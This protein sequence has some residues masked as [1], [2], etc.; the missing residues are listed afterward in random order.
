MICKKCGAELDEDALF[1]TEC[2]E[3]VVKNACPECGSELSEDAAFCTECGKKVAP[4][5]CPNCGKELEDE[6]KFCVYCGASI[7]QQGTAQPKAAENLQQGSTISANKASDSAN[8]KQAQ[9]KNKAPLIIAIIVAVIAVLAIAFA[10]RAYQ[11]KKIQ[12]AIQSFTEDYNQDYSRDYS[13][14]YSSESYYENSPVEIL[15]ATTAEYSGRP[16]VIVS[17]RWTN[18]ESTTQSALFNVS[19]Y[20]YQNGVELEKPI[21]YDE[22]DDMRNRDVKPGYSVDIEEAFYLDDMVSDIL[23]EAVPW[24]GSD[25]EAYTAK[26]FYFSDDSYDSEY[27]EYIF[28][29]S[30]SEYL[31]EE[32]LYGLSATELRIARNEIYARNGRMFNDENLQ[33][34]FDSCSWYVPSIPPE[35][36]KMWMLNDVERANSDLISSYEE[37]MGYK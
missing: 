3:K 31:T 16:I 18:P 9:N 15:E 6:S 14:G 8:N 27:S 37:A 13:D 20:A 2:G 30:D 10:V 7:E 4:L 28:P 1:C 34:Y 35:D 22:N 25:D 32:D 23:V 19:L 11:R 5:R 12:E 17:Y 29:Y 33:A 21:F 24:L 26:T 36:F